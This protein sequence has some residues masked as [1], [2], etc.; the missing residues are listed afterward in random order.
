MVHSDSAAAGEF[1]CSNELFNRIRLL[2]R[3]AQRSNLAHVITDCPHR[4]K[5]GWLEQYHLNGPSLRYEFDL[6]RLYSKTF[7]DMAD[8]Q[9]ADGLVPDIAP[10][11]VI[12]SGGFRDSPEWGSAIILAAW[13]HLIWTGDDTPLRRHYSAMQKYL[14]Y[15]GT[16]S[17]NHIVSHGFGRLV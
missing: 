9:Q 17:E 3:W 16:R 7:D 12:F 11:Y 13:Q 14:G 8:S 10:E 4:E 6:T 2:V 5:L 15:L 1:S